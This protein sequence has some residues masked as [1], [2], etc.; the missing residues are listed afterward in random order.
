MDGMRSG[1]GRERG[2]AVNCK[3]LGL[4]E[5]QQGASPPGVALSFCRRAR[6]RGRGQARGGVEGAG[7]GSA[8]PKL[9]G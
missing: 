7:A 6:G 1:A 5:R 3:D 4:D 8:P 9:N 2:S